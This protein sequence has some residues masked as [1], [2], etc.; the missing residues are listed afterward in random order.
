[1][2]AS[3]VGNGEHIHDAE[4]MTAPRAQPAKVLYVIATLDPAGAER[5]LVSLATHLDRTRFDP[6]VCCLTRGGP[7]ESQLSDAGIRKIVLG[8]KFKVDLAAVL[9]LSRL[10]RRERADIVHTWLFTGN[11]FGR[12]AALLAGGCAIVGSERSVDRWR[13]LAHVVVDR[14]LA[15]RTAKIIANA[16]A[17]KRFYVESEKI[18]A[19]KFVV[20][21]NGLDMEPFLEAR[22]W[23]LREELGLPPDAHVIGCVARLEEQKGIEYLL[24][25][26]R[27]VTAEWPRA[28][29]VVAGG[30]PKEAELR[31]MALDAGLGERFRFLGYRDN[32]PSLMAAFDVFVLPSLWEGLPNVVLEAMAA[33]CP[34]VATDVGGAGELIAHRE[35]GW[36]VPARDPQAI[37]DA[38]LGLLRDPGL[39]GRLSAAGR[40][41]ACGYTVERMVERTQRVYDEVLSVRRCRA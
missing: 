7:L 13:T 5:Q 10:I 3:S 28:V 20:V 6:V 39:A 29:F 23:P 14:V 12:A 35:S 15:S 40:V 21:P 33:G 37:A 25:A 8:K 16:E 22:P 32:V 18:P 31:A 2:P 41:T 30:G 1:M 36:L 19:R 24:R 34:V 38:V 9:R 17:V 4:P 27:V 11:A 26:A